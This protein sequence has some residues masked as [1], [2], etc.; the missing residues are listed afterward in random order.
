MFLALSPAEALLPVLVA[1]VDTPKLLGL[2]TMVF[3]S[4]YYSESVIISVGDVDID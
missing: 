1:F 2:I 3:R 4:G